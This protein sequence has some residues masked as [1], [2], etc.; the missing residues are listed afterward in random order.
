MTE[1]LTISLQ[2]SKSDDFMSA[3]FFMPLSA[4]LFNGS[5]F[6]DFVL[7]FNVYADRH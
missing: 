5:I 3:D 2:K 1:R 4:L 7:R 6:Y